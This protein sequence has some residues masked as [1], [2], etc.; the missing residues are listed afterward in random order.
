MSTT[1]ASIAGRTLVIAVLAL[2]TA[3]AV[4]A[5]RIVASRPSRVR[6][7]SDGDRIKMRD[8][9][10]ALGLDGEGWLFFTSETC[11]PCRTVKTVLESTGDDWVEV[12]VDRHPDLFK[13]WGVYRVPTLIRTG[14]DGAPLQR[15]GPQ[16]ARTAVVGE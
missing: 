15:H 7:T 10:E 5:Y 9:A 1:I 3:G 14:S 12:D 2:A 4:V 13:L 16:S 11:A 6:E 8:A